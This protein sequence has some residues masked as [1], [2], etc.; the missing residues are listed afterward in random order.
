[1]SFGLRAYKKEKDQS[2][3]SKIDLDFFLVGEDLSLYLV[4]KELSLKE[5]S[6]HF[7]SQFNYSFDELKKMTHHP[8]NLNRQ[9]EQTD[10]FFYKDQKWHASTGRIKPLYELTMIEKYFTGQESEENI[11]DQVEP[12]KEEN[13]S[14]TKIEKIIFIAEDQ[15]WEI[16]LANQ[17]IFKSK[18]I[19]WSRNP[20][21]FFSLCP[22][23]QVAANVLESLPTYEPQSFVLASFKAVLRDLVQGKT[24]FLPASISN[25]SGYYIMK[26]SLDLLHVFY[27]PKEEVFSTDDQFK[28]IKNMKRVIARTFDDFNTQSDPTWMTW[29]DYLF[30]F[31]DKNIMNDTE[32]DGL[33]FYN[34]VNLF[35]NKSVNSFL[36]FKK[37]LDSLTQIL[38]K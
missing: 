11:F 9:S 29:N 33:F 15:N 10:Y 27:A 7:V 23:Y 36:S 2:V 8:F 4:A 38:D 12:V 32:F 25:D 17:K 19:I 26:Q 18:N 24:Y 22:S 21:D 13:F 3:I 34:N 16:Y 31:I 1:M 35:F 14:Q 37:D 30:H 6:F 5:K 20:F 28:T